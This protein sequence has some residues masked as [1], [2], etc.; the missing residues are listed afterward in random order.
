MLWIHAE[1]LRSGPACGMLDPG[2]KAGKGAAAMAFRLRVRDLTGVVEIL[3]VCGA[4]A[5]LFMGA[6]LVP[7][8]A[9]A[10]T[11]DHQG[12][13]PTAGEC[14][15]E[16]VPPAGV[17]TAFGISAGPGGVW[18]SHGGT[19]DRVTAAGIQEFPI[20]DAAT[21]SAGTLAYKPGG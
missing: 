13:P 14:V 15:T 21:A 17:D 7:T 4:A 20:P 6:A 8:A 1:A 12:P 3:S 11:D 9:V 2:Q 10:A 5:T 16:F 18:F 19:L